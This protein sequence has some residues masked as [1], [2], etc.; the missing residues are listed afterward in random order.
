MEDQVEKLLEDI[1]ENSSRIP[2]YNLPFKHSVANQPTMV[3]L[4]STMNTASGSKYNFSVIDISLPRQLQQVKSI[5]LMDATIPLATCSIPDTACVFWYYRTSV[6]SGVVPNPE[7]LYMVRLLPSTYKPEYISDPQNYGFNHTFEDYPTLATELQKACVKDL[8][9]DNYLDFGD[10]PPSHDIPFLTD[11]I[12]IPYNTTLN[13][14]QMTGTNAQTQLAFKDYLDTT[15]YGLG[16]VVYSGAF[17]YKSLQTGNTGNAL[18][19][20]SWW[21]IV[22]GEVVIEWDTDTPYR[23]GRYVAFDNKLYISIA[24]TIGDQ[25]D[26]SSTYW[27]EIIADPN[28]IQYR[29]LITGYNDPNVALKQSTKYRQ[30]NKYAL[31]EKNEKVEYNGVFWSAF[32]QTQGVQPFDIST[33]QTWIASQQYSVN[34]VVFWNGNFYR[35][36][37][38][39]NVNSEPSFFSN[40]WDLNAWE[41]TETAPLISGLS[42]ITQ[43]WD[44]VEVKSNGGILLPFPIGVAG[45]PFVKNPVRLLNSIL[46]FVWNGIFDG[47]VLSTIAPVGYN[48]RIDTTQ[49]E[50][51]NRVR[52]IPPYMIADL[53]LGIGLKPTASTISQ[54]FVADGYCNLVYTNIIHI[55]ASIVGNATQDLLLDNNLLAIA[56]ANSGNLG[57]AFYKPT[58]VNPIFLRDADVSSITFELRDEVG[59]PYLL[60]NNAIV[61]MVLKITYKQE[62]DE[63]KH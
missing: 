38:N 13:R 60:G 42:Q 41:I 48:T 47:S 32:Y 33:A 26:T 2:L 51:F 52:P 36:T 53:S 23:I 20:T 54:T 1:E 61:S 25:P 39:N 19:N 56:S 35:S 28:S 40:V 43:D 37:I 3:S 17:T 34:N 50:L 9:Y 21:K 18:N 5:Q 12:S 8:A 45:Q 16:D 4:N 63:K 46:G 29:Y 62:D 59:E 22:N 57:I 49:T 15:T 27:S 6:Y 24:N 44:M 11:E 55:Y 7:N 14:F 10:L 31:F 30:W 58:L